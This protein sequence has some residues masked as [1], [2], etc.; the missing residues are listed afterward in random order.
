MKLLKLLTLILS[1]SILQCA[2]I[3]ITKFIDLKRDAIN[4]EM[5][6]IMNYDKN[7]YM[8]KLKHLNKESNNEIE[9]NKVNL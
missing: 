2:S 9:N 8:R 4:E 1:I 7:Q 6:E 3:F 5:K